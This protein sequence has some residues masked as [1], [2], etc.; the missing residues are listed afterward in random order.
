MPL[1]GSKIAIAMSSRDA[2]PV[3]IL[4]AHAFC[5]FAVPATIV[6]TRKGEHSGFPFLFF[7][8]LEAASIRYLLAGQLLRSIDPPPPTLGLGE[9]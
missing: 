4:V 2:S 5:R 1:V 6:P 9:T 7:P 8:D 3:F